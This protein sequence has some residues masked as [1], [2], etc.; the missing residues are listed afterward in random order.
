MGSIFSSD[1]NNPITL[2]YGR[3]KG[4]VQRGWGQPLGAGSRSY[5]SIARN[6]YALPREHTFR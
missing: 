2:P 4:W 3:D 6:M 1:Y 5:T